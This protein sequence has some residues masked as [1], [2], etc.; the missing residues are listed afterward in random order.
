VKWNERVNALLRGEPIDRI[1]FFTFTLGFCAKNV[2]FP[3][4]SIYS[5]PEKSFYAQ[6]WTQEQYGYDSGPFYGYASYGGAEFGGEIKL[7]DGEYEQA[8]SH[9]SFAVY[10]EEDVKKLAMPDV[11]KA[12]FIPLAMEFSLLQKRHDVPISLVVGGPFTIAGNI[13]PVET[14]C[15]WII[16]K[17]EVA[18]QL[19]R[20]ATDHIKDIVHY[21]VETFGPGQVSLQIWEPLASNQIISPKQFEKMVF[22]YVKELGEK[23]ISA[24]IRSTL[25]HICGE[26]NQNLPYWAK[27]PMGKSDIASF[28][29]EVDI[30]TAIRNFESKCIIAG[31]IEPAFIQTGSPHEIY[32]LCKITIEKG[33]LAP[34][35]FILMPGCETPVNTP[36]YNFFTMV[37]ALNDFGKL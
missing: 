31:N 14:L 2:G 1:P 8:P 18:H 13:C 26:Q 7:P 11:K 30:T 35:G 37:K 15:R 20:I 17:P 24:K 36:P 4:S 10:E 25:W 27:V 32:E 22:P 16:K 28:G 6:L 23:F 33:K 5:N 9:G 3:L 21:W 12:G 19:L 29:R 34:R